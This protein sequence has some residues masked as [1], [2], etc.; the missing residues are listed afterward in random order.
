MNRN[1]PLPR[2]LLGL[3]ALHR[4]LIVLPVVVAL[5]LGVGWALR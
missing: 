4:L 5:W 1:M 3:G 2:T